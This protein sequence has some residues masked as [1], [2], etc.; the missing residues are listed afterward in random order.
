LSPGRE[1]VVALPFSDFR[2]LKAFVVRLPKKSW[3]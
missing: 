2:L 3:W 1:Q